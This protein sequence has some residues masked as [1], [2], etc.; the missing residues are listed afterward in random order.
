[1]TSVE[2]IFK[3][4]AASAREPFDISI[5]SIAQAIAKEFNVTEDYAMTVIDGQGKGL[6]RPGNR[7]GGRDRPDPGPLSIV[8]NYGIKNHQSLVPRPEMSKMI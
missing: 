1:M 5:K 6:G 4:F 8:L 7:P 3:E 2:K